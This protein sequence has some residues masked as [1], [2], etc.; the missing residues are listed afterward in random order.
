MNK[1]PREYFEDNDLPIAGYYAQYKGATLEVGKTYRQNGMVYW[2]DFKIVYVGEGVALGMEVANG[3]NSYGIGGKCLF[4]A[5]G[6][7]SGWKYKDQRPQYV[8][9]ERQHE[10]R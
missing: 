3:N 5:E 6:I 7:M 10:Q 1:K 8:L 2:V 4:V 9:K